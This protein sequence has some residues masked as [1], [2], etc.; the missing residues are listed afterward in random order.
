MLFPTA[1]AGPMAPAC[2][3]GSQRL[4]GKVF[5]LR[6]DIERRNPL[7]VG[8]GRTGSSLRLKTPVGGESSA[9]IATRVPK[10]VGGATRRLPLGPA[11]GCTPGGSHQPARQGRRPRRVAPARNDP[12]SGFSACEWMPR[13]GTLSWWDPVARNPLCGLKRYR[14]RVRLAIDAKGGAAAPPSY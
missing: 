2:R 7:M 4:R 6:V 3:T 11:H 5:S 14:R 12:A 8:S 9:G 1:S 13:H 10:A